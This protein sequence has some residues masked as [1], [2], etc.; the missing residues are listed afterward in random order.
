MLGHFQQ[1]ALVISA[2]G[3]P[4]KKAQEADTPLTSCARTVFSVAGQ[5]P[6]TERMAVTI[7]REMV[8]CDAGRK[9]G[10][11]VTNSF[12]W[13]VRSDFVRFKYHLSARTG[14]HS[15]SFASDEKDLM[16]GTKMSGGV[17]EL[18]WFFVKKPVV[19]TRRTPPGSH[20]ICPVSTDRACSSLRRREVA[21][22][23]RNANLTESC[24]SVEQSIGS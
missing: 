8:H 7:H 13:S 12:L 20:R 24:R 18:D 14:H 6:G 17:K 4:L 21:T 19:G 15:L 22:A 5:P 2:K 10:V 16:S 3:T 1:A 11:V 23:R 9:G